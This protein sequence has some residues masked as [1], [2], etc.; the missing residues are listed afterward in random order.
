M[1][2]RIWRQKSKKIE[3]KH[4]NTLNFSLKYTEN[5]HTKYSNKISIFQMVFMPNIPYCLSLN[6]G[7]FIKENRKNSIFV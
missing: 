1:I 3:K 2:N 6:Y 4:R 5:I 7:Y